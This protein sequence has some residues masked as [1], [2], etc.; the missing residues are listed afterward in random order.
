MNA[1]TLVKA[2]TPVGVTI[3]VD[4]DAETGITEIAGLDEYIWGLANRMEL[5]DIIKELYDRGATEVDLD[6]LI[7]NSVF[8]KWNIDGSFVT[9]VPSGAGILDIGDETSRFMPLS[10]TIN[11]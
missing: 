4:V 11:I 3:N 9:L 8:E 1:N 5:S 10:I 7:A 6:D 2:F